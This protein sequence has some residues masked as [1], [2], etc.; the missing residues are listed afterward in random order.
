MSITSLELSFD[1]PMWY[2]G[3]V[4]GTVFYIYYWLEAVKVG[5]LIPMVIV[6]F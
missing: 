5:F 6:I 1:L 3:A 2:L 4:F